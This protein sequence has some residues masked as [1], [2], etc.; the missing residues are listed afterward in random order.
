MS[1]TFI[2][3]QNHY[4]CEQFLDLQEVNPVVLAV[5]KVLKFW[6]SREEL[7]PI[8]TSGSTGVPKVWYH[9]RT[10]L[11]A[12]A[13][14]TLSFFNLQPGATAVLGLP[15][16]RIGGAMMVIRTLVGGLTLHVLEPKLALALPEAPIDF[17]PLTL[18]QYEQLSSQSRARVHTL[19]LGGSAV[20]VLPMPSETTV[21]VG[22]GMTETASHVAL[23]RLDAALYEAV[24]S[25]RFSVASSGALCIHSPHLG[26]ESLE[27]NDVVDLRDE[28][29]FSV[30]GRLDFVINSGGIKIQPEVGERALLQK[31][32]SAVISYREDAVFGQ[33]PVLVLRE[34]EALASARAELA[35]WEK[36]NRPKSYALCAQWPETV[37]GKLDRL[38]LAAWIK[39]HPDRLFPIEGA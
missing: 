10:R 16:D 25:T 2:W 29:S 9:P 12:S 33:L 37:G 22:Y 34:K 13:R 6:V 31:G 39:S 8:S 30:E 7:L 21:F 24:G 32:V 35:N 27:T 28:R 5:Q 14:A 20:P 38:A 23:R 26:I 3:K 4:S 15:A 36:N 17:L 18:P 1:A 11:E 19:L